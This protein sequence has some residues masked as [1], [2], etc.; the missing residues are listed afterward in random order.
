M[1]QMIVGIDSENSLV[2]HLDWYCNKNNTTKVTATVDENGDLT[3]LVDGELL[4]C[5]SE[6][7]CRDAPDRGLAE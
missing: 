6:N 2:M 3:I 5:R 4:T 1:T 7:Q